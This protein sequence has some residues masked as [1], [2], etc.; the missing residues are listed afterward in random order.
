MVVKK[1]AYYIN[2]AD[3]YRILVRKKLV[4]FPI[5][6]LFYFFKVIMQFFTSVREH[7]F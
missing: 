1:V 4:K 2:N 5:L 6:I 7:L 3:L